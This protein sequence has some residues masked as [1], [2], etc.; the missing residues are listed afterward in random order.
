MLVL[1]KELSKKINIREVLSFF[2][3]FFAHFVR[4]GFVFGNILFSSGLYDS[5]F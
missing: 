3:F 4:A 1:H 5:T 2:V